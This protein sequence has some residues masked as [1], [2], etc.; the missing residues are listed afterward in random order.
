M[1]TTEM[2]VPKELGSIKTKVL[3]G[4]GSV[5]FGVK[6]NGFQTILLPFYNLV[7]HIP[8]WKVG[9]AIFIAQFFDAF[10]DPI[11]GHY[12]DNLRTQWGRRHPLMY[13][14][15]LP[16][17]ISYLL[18][19][20]PPGWSPDALFGYLIVVAIIV[21][22]FISFYEI[23]SSALVP[24]LTQD[25][26]QRTTFLSFRVFFAWYGGLGMSILAFSIFLTPDATHA[27]GQLNEVGYSKYG[28]TA[29]VVMLIAILVSAWGT[30]KFIP[31]FRKPE[32]HS[33][34]LGQYFRDMAATLTNHSFLIV[35]LAGAFLALAT[36]LVFALTFYV[37]TYFWLLPAKS[38]A[39]LTLSTLTAVLIAVLIAPVLSKRFGKKNAAVGMF[40]IGA[41]ISVMPLVLGLLHVLSASTPNLIYVLFGVSTI[42]TCLTIGSS[43]MIVS[44]V[45]DVVEDSE[46]R[47]GRRSE[48]LFFAGNSFIQKSASG[49]GLL[50]SGLVLWAVDFP[51]DA[52]PGLVSP[53]IV[54][55][56]ALLYLVV[57]LVLYGT[58]FLILSRFPISRQS[59]EENVR[60][61]MSEQAKA[62]V[63][64]PAPTV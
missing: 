14:A 13:A 58:G 46:I 40:L 61:L 44:M 9:L 48:G 3:Y 17:A 36:G 34:S 59:H 49:L 27:V 45:A 24:E 54:H 30:H 53:E 51:N 5:A 52:K 2:D 7:L 20:N 33:M 25:Y 10:I 4:F 43:V 19:W 62:G 60:R 50:A 21:R 15:A 18:L 38:L 28:M 1:A 6:D 42:G 23:P 47:T 32:G 16:V 26:D 31:H 37:N 63:E 55:D 22:T 12:S 29:A 11:I 8:A 57:V 56:F 41:V 39:F 35:F 64:P